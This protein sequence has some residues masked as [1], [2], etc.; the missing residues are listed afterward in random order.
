MIN[1]L[2]WLEKRPKVAWSISAA[3]ML[4]I[5]TLSSFS[6]PPQPG[7]IK[8]VSDTFK[9]FLEYLLFG[10]L[11]LISFKSTGKTRKNAFLLAVVAASFYGITDEV[12]QLFVA[13]RTASFL[14]VIADSAGGIFGAF[15]SFFCHKKLFKRSHA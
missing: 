1:P 10:F 8:P 7:I 6:N 14:D 3:Y 13:G 5:F 2:L 9:H 15:T 11:L 12:H 4:V